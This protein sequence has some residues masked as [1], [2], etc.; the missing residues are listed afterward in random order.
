[1]KIFK[2][3]FGFADKIRF[4]PDYVDVYVTDGAATGFVNGD[5]VCLSDDLKIK[6]VAAAGAPQPDAWFGCVTETISG[7]GSGWVRVSGRH[8]AAKI[9]AGLTKGVG[10]QLKAGN[11]LIAQSLAGIAGEYPCGIL[12]TN[13][14]GG[15]AT[16]WIR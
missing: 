12:V 11:G 9:A 3:A 7:G 1:M 2:S 15:I 8:T 6:T 10:I 14:S 5:W 13:E 16:V 4:G